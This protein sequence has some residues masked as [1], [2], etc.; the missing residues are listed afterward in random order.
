MLPYLGGFGASYRALISTLSDDWDVWTA[1]PPGHGP[2]LDA[3]ISRLDP[4]VGRYLDALVPVLRPGSVVFGHSMGGAVAYH[5]LQRL[6]ADARFVG[7][8]PSALVV[9]GCAA[10]RDLPRLGCSAMSDAD[11]V[12]HLTRSGAIPTELAADASLL[13][14][15]LP[16][17]RA[18]YGVLDDA[19]RPA[20]ARLGTP[21]HLILGGLDDLTPAGTAASWQDYLAHRV[22]THVLDGLGHMFVRDA[23]AAVDAVLHRLHTGD[24]ATAPALT[25]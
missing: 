9:S 11:L 13:E 5:L 16:A 3:P 14:L 17:F 22:T 19:R 23:S 20:Q 1:N 4:L 21:T 18:D 8:E 10:P 2:A 6:V 25:R 15:F 12:A 7:R 24:L